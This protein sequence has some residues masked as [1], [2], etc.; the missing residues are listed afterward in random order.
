[1]SLPEATSHS[2]DK[3]TEDVFVL[4]FFNTTD[5]ITHAFDPFYTATSLS[6]ATD[7]NVLHELKEML[8]EAGVYDWCEVEE[9]NQLYFADEPAERISPIIDICAERFAKELELDDDQKADFKIKAK[10][11]QT[12]DRYR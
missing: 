9:F 5:E 7:V 6:S 12:R 8:D 4:D 2:L 10:Q 11:L 3:R 1:M